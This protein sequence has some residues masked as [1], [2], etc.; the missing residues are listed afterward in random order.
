MPTSK[1]RVQVTLSPGEVRAIERYAERIGCTSGLAETIRRALR[2]QI[3]DMP[4]DTQHGGWRGG[5]KD[6]RKGKGD[7]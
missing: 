3:P 7:E 1:T 6:S 5:P 4:H 2:A